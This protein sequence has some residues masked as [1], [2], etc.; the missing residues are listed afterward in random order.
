M[1]S[2][3]LTLILV[4]VLFGSSLNYYAV[5]KLSS[6]AVATKIKERFKAQGEPLFLIHD[7]KR[8]V[9]IGDYLKFRDKVVLIDG[10]VWQ[11]LAAE[12]AFS[13][14]E[15]IAVTT[16]KG[17]SNSSEWY[18]K[19][20]LVTSNYSKKSYI[21]GAEILKIFEEQFKTAPRNENVILS[22]SGGRA[23]LVVPHRFINSLQLQR[24]AKSVKKGKM[25]WSVAPCDYA[26]LNSEYFWQ[27]WAA[28]P[29]EPS[30]SI[31]YSLSG[32]LP[33]GVVW[34]KS[35]H[36]LEG[37]PVEEGHFPLQFTARSETQKITMACT[38]KVQ[39]NSAPIWAN[40]PD[41][42][43]VS[44][45][46]GTISLIM[47]DNEFP[48]RELSVTVKSLPTGLSYIDTLSQFLWDPKDSAVVGGN[49]VLSVEDPIGA[50]SEYE[51]PVYYEADGVDIGYTFATLTPPWDTLVEN[52][53]YEWDL[54]REK[55]HWKK[56]H[57]QM[58]LGEC[59]DTVILR[60]TSL[61][62]NPGSDSLFTV[63]FRF[64]DREKEVT[65]YTVNLPVI[66]NREPYFEAFP[67]RWDIDIHD[68]VYFT[69]KA[70]DPEGEEVTL[71]LRSADSGFVFHDGRLSFSA[72]A[73]GTYQAFFEA[74]DPHGNIAVQ[75]VTYYVKKVYDRYRG[76]S[77]EMGIWPGV[78]SWKDTSWGYMR[79]YRFHGEVPALR[80]GVFSPDDCNFYNSKDF[81]MPF[82]YVGTNLIPAD[83][84]AL[85]K[86]AALDLGFSY[87]IATQEI[88]TFGLYINAEF[89]APMEK[90]FNSYLDARFMFFARHLLRKVSVNH[91]INDDGS[92]DYNTV[93][94][95][96]LLEEFVSPDNFNI[97][98]GATQ[99]FHLGF[100]A[101]VGPTFQA[102]IAPVAMTFEV[103]EHPDYPDDIDSAK[104]H[105]DQTKNIYSA[106]FGLGL[107]YDLKIKHFQFENKVRM[108]Y[109]GEDYGFLVYYD[110]ILGFGRFKR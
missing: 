18:K 75:Q 110:C 40:V 5:G 24:V 17:S 103:E 88:H 71:T 30:G 81:R 33:K 74:S 93:K 53:P 84:R 38:L 79:S 95:I 65:S 2:L 100:G 54:S 50:K 13:N 102:R 15:K 107:R 47:S 78:S 96:E 37:T 14:I 31:N 36:S 28:D 45:K 11:T 63:T 32:T 106:M 10:Q 7:S 55:K 67:D 90:L 80:F 85:G 61:Y 27:I 12:N 72:D 104:V 39:E 92:H 19:S 98:M 22:F 20:Q 73:P 97:F 8:G 66:K 77:A 86:S 89:E 51:V 76:F 109:A 83:K 69:P 64:R 3:L 58:K 49:V 34:N 23:T 105:L 4:G 101:F 41:T 48:S 46:A 43:R 91:T 9:Q 70:V 57:L 1:K 52:V 44:D 16:L 42:L 99:W 87:N 82:V 59:S 62:M 26:Y 6:P 60:D 108:G 56:N 21:L 94:D 68:M 25:I 35:L 29:A